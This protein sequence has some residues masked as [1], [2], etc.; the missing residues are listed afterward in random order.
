[1]DKPKCRHLSTWH[2]LIYF[3]LIG[4]HVRSYNNFTFSKI[5][6]TSTQKRTVFRYSAFPKSK[7]GNPC[8]GDWNACSNISFRAPLNA[9]LRYL[10]D[11]VLVARTAALLHKSCPSL[12]TRVNSYRGRRHDPVSVFINL[13]RL[14]LRRR[15]FYWS[16]G[17]QQNWTKLRYYA[18]GGMILRRSKE[19][20][21]RIRYFLS[22][23]R[24]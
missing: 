21:I 17:R 1:M 5:S 18:L 15:V 14:V 20:S 24:N 3:A 6:A 12:K 22:S 7:Q 10:T 11:A 4:P 23:V 9:L 13:P 8:W 2:I 16:T 19:G